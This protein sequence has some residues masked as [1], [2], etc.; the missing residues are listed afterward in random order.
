MRPRV[1]LTVCAALA[2]VLIAAPISVYA[3][4]QFT[5]VPTSNI[6]HDDIA[7]LSN[8]GVTKGCNPSGT[9]FCPKDFVTREQ[10]AAFMHRLATNRV[11]DAAEVQGLSAVELVSQCP[12]GT[13][14]FVSACIENTA[15]PAAEWIAAA[16][17]CAAEG[18]RLPATGELLGFRELPG[19][20][21]GA[22]WTDDVADST[23]GFV[24]YIATDVGTGTIEDPFSPLQYRCVAGLG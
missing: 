5:D 4:H 13:T 3:S 1:L 23:N 8:G 21:L 19:V 12:P 16:Q 6:F 17:V 24:I 14:L 10:M 11:V 2:G 9:E 15:R 22:E 18:R 7:W 20:T